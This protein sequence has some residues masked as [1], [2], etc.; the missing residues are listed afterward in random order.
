MRLIFVKIGVLTGIM[1]SAVSNCVED[2][3]RISISVFA[4]VRA[5]VCEST[6]ILAEA[7]NGSQLKL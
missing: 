4:C 1:M 6:E 7:K 5:R 2:W 3:V